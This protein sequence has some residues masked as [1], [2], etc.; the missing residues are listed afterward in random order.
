VDEYGCQ[1]KALLALP[2]LLQGHAGIQCAEQIFQVVKAFGFQHRLGSITSDNAS[3]MTTMATQLE[4]LLRREGVEWSAATNRLRCLGHILNIAVQ[5]FLFVRDKDAL[6]YASQQCTQQPLDQA[7]GEQ[8]GG[9]CSMQP[10][11]K[12]KE[13]AIAL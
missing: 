5:A 12:V 8:A 7:L 11:L 1:Q 3:A 10:L 9:W 2:E 13:L 6:D 4:D